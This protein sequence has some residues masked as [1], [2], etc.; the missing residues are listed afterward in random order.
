[1]CKNK[2]KLIS[3]KRERIASIHETT[4]RNWER[5]NTAAYIHPSRS[6][7]PCTEVF[8]FTTAPVDYFLLLR[9]MPCSYRMAL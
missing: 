5:G 9:G 4:P 2:I 7:P 8:S 1:M 3:E 6:S